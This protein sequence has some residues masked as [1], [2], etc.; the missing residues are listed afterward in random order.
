MPEVD[1]K[2]GWFGGSFFGD[3]AENVTKIESFVH[4]NRQ[5]NQ[6]D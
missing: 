6:R 2:T 5:L 1:K 3:E 4:L